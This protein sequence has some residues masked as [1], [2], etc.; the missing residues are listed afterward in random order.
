[1]AATTL[2]SIN[3]FPQ[4]L[5]VDAEK[6]SARTIYGENETSSERDPAC[7]R[8]R[9]L[10]VRERR[11]LEDWNDLLNRSRETIELHLEKRISQLFVQAVTCYR[12]DYLFREGRTFRQG[13]TEEAIALLKG[14]VSFAAAHSA[15]LP[16]L[17]ARPKEG[18][19]EIVFQYGSGIFKESNATVGV[20][21]EVNDADRAIDEKRKDSLLRVKAV[22]LLNQA[23]R[24]ERTPVQ[25]VERFLTLLK[26]EIENS[27]QKENNEKVKDVLR[28]YLEKADEL[29]PSIAD[30]ETIDRW[31]NLQ[32]S[33]P[34]LP[35]ISANVERIRRGETLS[36][37]AILEI[38]RS[39]IDEV[40]PLIRQTR[41]QTQNENRAPF[42]FRDL[43]MGEIFKRLSSEKIATVE[44][45]VGVSSSELSEKI[46]GFQRIKKTT[47]ILKEHA[48][49]IERVVEEIIPFIQAAREKRV[50]RKTL[51]GLLEERKIALRP[52]IYRLRYKMIQ[53]DQNA[54]SAIHSRIES[55]SNKI[56]NRNYAQTYFHAYLLDSASR[57]ESGMLCRLLHISSAQIAQRLREI[58][59]NQ[60]AHATLEKN[61][62]R[63]SSL[64]NEIDR[65]QTVEQ[66]KKVAQKIQALKRQIVSSSGAKSITELFYLRLYDHSSSHDLLGAIL[67]EPY[68]LQKLNGQVERLASGKK[69]S[70]AEEAVQNKRGEIEGALDL[71][72]EEV[73][74]LLRSTREFRSQLMRELRNSHN[75]SQDH[76][77]ALYRRLFPGYP[78]SDGTLSNLE[79]GKKIITADI[80]EQISNIFGVNS[81]LFYPSHFAE[82]V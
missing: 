64:G 36:K 59:V 37:E 3:I 35:T 1:M 26:K 57:E 63:I 79:S 69:L 5:A 21:K 65:A 12:T 78:M 54:Q 39:K 60:K 34:L 25:V 67:G 77:K 75:M 24:G 38:I 49:K 7:S 19:E 10:K 45:A 52:S 32:L 56:G 44:A 2:V 11:P 58:R 81:T 43:Y 23:S 30:P 20:I 55:I 31:L 82:S 51:T 66:Q 14:K 27:I 42:H 17:Y 29:E 6:L 8:F 80:I 22:E 68:T 40:P 47:E 41:H 15:T 61:A 50:D 48:E 74:E 73:G 72:R 28:L 70:K 4:M 13:H 53:A 18:G 9:I 16:T 33:N 62:S 46:K 71:F 76:F